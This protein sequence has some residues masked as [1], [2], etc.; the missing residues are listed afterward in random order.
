MP[1]NSSMKNFIKWYFFRFIDKKKQQRE[2]KKLEKDF[3]WFLTSHFRQ[4]GWM[5]LICS[6]P[7]KSKELRALQT[8]VYLF[9][10]RGA[11]SHSR[12]ARLVCVCVC[13]RRTF[14][15]RHFTSRN[16]HTANTMQ[17]LN[18]KKLTMAK[19]A[20]SRNRGNHLAFEMK[21]AATTTFSSCFVFFL[22]LSFCIIQAVGCARKKIHY[23]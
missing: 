21:N 8:N 19:R 4:D 9:V 18:T 16:K 2:K 12:P 3:N 14:H 15:N 10:G 22:L 23:A 11:R 7:R 1:F 17:K 20:T 13:Q 5:A 6:L